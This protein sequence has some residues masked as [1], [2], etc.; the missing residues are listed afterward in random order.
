MMNFPRADIY[1]LITPDLLHQLVKGTF[2]D[3]LVD[4]VSEYL[5]L[6]Y[7]PS[8]GQKI[9]DDIDARYAIDYETPGSSDTGLRISLVPS[10]SGLRRFKH[11]RNF[12]QWTGADSKGL[13]KVE[14]A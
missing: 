10:F 8:R 7:G 12:K 2:K 4:W 6:R 11:G 1:E 13:M 9:L 5:T 14:Y 3:H